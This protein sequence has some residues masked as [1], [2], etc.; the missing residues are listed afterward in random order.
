M[1][2]KRRSKFKRLF[3]LRRSWVGFYRLQRP[4][5]G[6]LRAAYWAARLALLILK[7]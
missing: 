2:I 4:H 6:K 5:L 3:W 7:D 1:I